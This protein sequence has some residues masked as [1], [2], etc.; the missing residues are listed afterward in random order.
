MAYLEKLQK[1]H[2][3]TFAPGCIEEH[4]FVIMAQEDQAEMLKSIFALQ[5]QRVAV[6]KTLEQGHDEYLSKFPNYDFPIYRQVV[7]DCTE[8]FSSVSKKI[9]DIESKFAELGKTE[10]A[11]YIRKLQELEKEKL[12][13]TAAYQLAKQKVLDEPGC[14]E[15]EEEKAQLKQKLNS[16]ISSIAE[17]LENLK[18]EMEGL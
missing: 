6:Y 8:E 10:V 1:L 2:P 7:H 9:I 4:W 14:P 3:S 16:L 11:G 13:V 12:D 15:H 5:E 17:N 18:Y